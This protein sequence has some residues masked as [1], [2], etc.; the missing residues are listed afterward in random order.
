[1]ARRE[2]GVKV[3][4]RVSFE[5]AEAFDVQGPLDAA[6]ADFAAVLP[7]LGASVA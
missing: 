7:L 4:D 6:A 5:V 1:M 3:E 2:N